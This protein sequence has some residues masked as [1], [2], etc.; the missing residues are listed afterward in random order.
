MERL[1]QSPGNDADYK[2][3]KKKKKDTMRMRM[4]TRKRSSMI[5][6]T[7]T[8]TAPRSQA[9]PSRPGHVSFA[10]ECY[11][12][13]RALIAPKFVPLWMWAAPYIKFDDLLGGSLSEIVKRLRARHRSAREV[14]LIFTT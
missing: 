12:P 5:S 8:M 13:L 7:M 3:K 6:M 11:P 1:A 9:A 10:P 2:P 4:V 14:A